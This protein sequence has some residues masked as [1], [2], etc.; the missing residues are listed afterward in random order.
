MLN[1]KEG[2]TYVCVKS[3]RPWWTKGKEYKVVVNSQN[4]LCLV[5]DDG[6]K[7][8]ISYW[9]Y[10]GDYFKLKEE[11]TMLQFKEG[12]TFV[13]KRDDLGW[14]TKDKEYKVVFDKCHGLVI[15]DDDGSK[16]CLPNDKLLL[17]DVFKLKEKTVDL[18]KLTLEDLDEYLKLATELE[19]AKYLM[20]D[21]IER[22]TK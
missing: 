10:F 20:N 17:N 9:K 15:V 1:A 16:W 6:S 13:C 4:D 11:N 2:Q 12:Q 22:M 21:F 5:D 7:W 14:W 18:N 8:V 3:D 19:A